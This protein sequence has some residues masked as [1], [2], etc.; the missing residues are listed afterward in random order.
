MGGDKKGVKSY[1]REEKK[2]PS[3][4]LLNGFCWSRINFV[5]KAYKQ[6]RKKWIE[7]EEETGEEEEQ[8][9]RGF[10]TLL[11]LCYSVNK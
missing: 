3:S 6:S 10:L 11:H 2:G 4:M 7:E 5:L 9:G 1:T 8:Q